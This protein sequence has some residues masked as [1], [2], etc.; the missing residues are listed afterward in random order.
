[1]DMSE[2]IEFGNAQ[3]PP[4]FAWGF[5]QINGFADAPTSYA[6]L[7]RDDDDVAGVSIFGNGAD[8]A[9]NTSLIYI[10]MYRLPAAD[11]VFASDLKSFGGNAKPIDPATLALKN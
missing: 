10:K 6:R 8:A 3:S 9:Q 11:A 7:Y 2:V 5:L 1:M 4:S